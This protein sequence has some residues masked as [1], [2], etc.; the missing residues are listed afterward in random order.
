ME[1][2]IASLIKEMSVE[3]IIQ[4]IAEIEK[5]GD[6]QIFFTTPQEIDQME[7]YYR[8]HFKSLFKDIKDERAG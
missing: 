4:I 3:G 7:V 6:V 5:R 2:P 1:T 8:E